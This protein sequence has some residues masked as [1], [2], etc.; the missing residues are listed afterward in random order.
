MCAHNR[1]Q[2]FQASVVPS[3]FSL[4]PVSQ[5]PLSPCLGEQRVKEDNSPGKAANI[6]KL[7]ASPLC[8]LVKKTGEQ[9]AEVGLRLVS[10]LAQTSYGLTNTQLK[11]SWPLY[12]HPD[13]EVLQGYFSRLY[14]LGLEL[15]YMASSKNLIYQRVF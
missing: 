14:C 5:K 13:E 7:H 1:L 11:S 6:L 3:A 2:Y 8:L 12:F 10:H 9:R 4:F 15:N